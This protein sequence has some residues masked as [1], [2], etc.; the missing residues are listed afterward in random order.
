MLDINRYR[1]K[2]KAKDHDV[3]TLSRCEHFLSRDTTGLKKKT[4]GCYEMEASEWQDTSH[5]S[6]SRHNALSERMD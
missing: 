2:G 3:R 5:L 6:L 1:Q 4:L